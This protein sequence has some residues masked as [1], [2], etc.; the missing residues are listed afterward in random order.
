LKKKNNILNLQN[1]NGANT[2]TVNTVLK[3]YYTSAKAHAQ[4]F[5]IILLY[6]I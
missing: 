1:L 3:N 6:N 5:K 2:E 4:T